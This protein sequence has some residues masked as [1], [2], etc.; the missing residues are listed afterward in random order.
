MPKRSAIDPEL[1]E[2]CRRFEP[3]L[4]I[5]PSA[6]VVTDPHAAVV[7]WNPARPVEAWQ[8]L[9]LLGDAEELTASDG[10]A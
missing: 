5:S 1:E 9:E 10:G 6:L 3:V 7:A 2:Q 8:L 4:Q